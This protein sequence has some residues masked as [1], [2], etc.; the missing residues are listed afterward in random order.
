MSAIARAEPQP[1]V[2]APEHVAVQLVVS[3]K[4]P[5]PRP[6]SVAP[7]VWVGVTSQLTLGV[8][9]SDLSIDRIAPKASLCV[10][11]DDLLCPRFYRG[12]GIDVRYRV[13]AGELT[14]VPHARL[15]L[16]DIEP[17]K[18]AIT[19]GAALRWTR[20]RITLTTDP[21]LQLG[22]MNTNRGN[23]SAMW[24]PV[25]ISTAVNHRVDTEVSSGWNSDLAVIRDGWHLPLEIAV[26]VRVTAQVDVRMG[27]GFT[28]LLGPQNTL[29]ER[30]WSVALWWW[31][32][33]GLFKPRF[34]ATF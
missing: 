21:F 13:L 16:R 30:L 31:P 9:H 33:R 6:L 12:S 3:A 18:P 11:H 32:R 24:L 1:L 28:S 27:V 19:L 5:N 25:V 29:K 17:L 23:R 4:F 8:I 34:P 15:L 26:R 20:G 10:R 22:L 7:D 2:L 14:V